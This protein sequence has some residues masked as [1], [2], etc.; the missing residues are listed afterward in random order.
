MLCAQVNSEGFV[1]LLASQPVE[2]SSCALVIGSG[3][4]W[5]SNPFLLTVPDAYAIG[6]AISLAWGVAWTVKTVITF[7]QST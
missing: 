1:Q 6:G 7:F 4:E 2:V 5:M 3:S